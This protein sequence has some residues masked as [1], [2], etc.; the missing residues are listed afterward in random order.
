[1]WPEGAEL[2]L[3]AKASLSPLFIQGDKNNRFLML[4]S[5]L[6]LW[7]AKTHVCGY[8]NRKRHSILL[9]APKWLSIVL[10]QV[11]QVRII[12]QEKSPS[13]PCPR[14]T[15]VFKKKG[16]MG[17][18]SDVWKTIRSLLALSGQ[19]MQK[20]LQAV[21]L[22]QTTDFIL[23][24]TWDSIVDGIVV[25]LDASRPELLGDGETSGQ[26]AVGH[27][28]ANQQVHHGQLADAHPLV[29]LH[30][31]E[32]FSSERWLRADWTSHFGGAG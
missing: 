2:Y 3:L 19:D 31:S 5:L 8:I 11:L 28:V 12:F 14:V 17:R 4:V 13:T 15:G 16:G 23:V 24:L 20:I 30:K 29:H 26:P 7:K 6:L 18:M 10:M 25:A 27:P 32:G 9:K 22:L 21:G 1:M